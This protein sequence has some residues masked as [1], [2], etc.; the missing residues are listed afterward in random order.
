[1]KKYMLF[2]ALVSLLT[3]A[4]SCNKGNNSGVNEEEEA[5]LIDALKAKNLLS[6]L[7]RIET[8]EDGTVKY[9]PLIGQAIESS[10]PTTY[11]TVAETEAD[12]RQIFYGIIAVMIDVPDNSFEVN[13]V[14]Q[15]DVHLKFQGKGSGPETAVI[16][17]DCPKLKNV[18]TE[19]VFLPSASWP[20]NAG[21]TPFKLLS[22]W[23]YQGLKY[24]CVRTSENGTGIMLTFDGGWGEEWFKK[25]SYWQ[26][27]FYLWTNTAQAEA[28]DCWAWAIY[29]KGTEYMQML[30]KMGADKGLWEKALLESVSFDNNYSYDHGIWWAYACYYVTIKRT[31]I[32]AGAVNH[33]SN[34]FEHKQTP[35][36]TNPSSQITFDSNFDTSG[37][38]CIYKGV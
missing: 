1:M 20:T 37:W 32:F 24:V 6:S 12:A 8:L 2:F 26:G 35:T 9:T 3:F 28:F 17:V 31:S 34:D 13:E 15:G 21:S 38:E 14:K 19:I 23:K 36:R 22:V 11:Y 29:N 5:A 4:V 30:K 33:Y 25:Y 16:T 18:L 7:C 10:K 27:E